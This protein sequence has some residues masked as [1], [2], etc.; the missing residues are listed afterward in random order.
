MSVSDRHIKRIDKMISRVF[1]N[2]SGYVALDSDM[3]GKRIRLSTGKKSEPRLLKWYKQNFESEYRKLYE[4]KLGVQGEDNLTFKEYG[5]LVLKITSSN[6]SS[7]SQ[8]EAETI[9][10]K[11][12]DFFGDMGIEN[13]KASDIMMW[14]NSLNLAPKTILNYRAYLNLVMQTAMNDDILRKNPVSL[15]PAPKNIRNKPKTVY[16][17]DELIIIIQAAKGQLQNYIQLDSFTG[18]RGSEMIALQW[19][20]DIDF[21]NDVLTVNSRIREGIEDVPK[22]GRVRYIPLF[23][24]AK[25]ALLRQRKLTG[26]SKYVFLNQSGIP[27]KTPDS[28]STSFKTLTKK[29]DLKEGTIHDLRRSFNTLLK[30][31]NYPP[32]WILDIMGHVDEDVN[33]NHYTGLLKVN[34]QGL[35]KIAL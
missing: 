12:C 27:Y 1:V 35:K 29:L 8:Q 34:M 11:L 31:Y 15:V 9:F 32:D 24:Q 22:S 6:R 16:Y 33:R 10:R 14:Q 4:H 3:F 7:F 20:R 5:E 30:Q 18:L 2:S 25:E 19:D 26:L 17:E 21:E 28:I 23:P 13:I